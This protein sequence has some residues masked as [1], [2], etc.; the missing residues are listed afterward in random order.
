MLISFY[1]KHKIVSHGTVQLRCNQP[2]SVLR[3][4]GH[5]V[6]VKTIYLSKPRKGELVILHRAKYDR[7][8]SL[9][10]NYAR[11]LGCTIWYDLDDLLFSPDAER[12]L[13]HIGN[14][15]KDF[16]ANEY[17][18]CIKKC[19]KIL[20]STA[21]LKQQLSEIHAN[22]E[23]V[24]NFLSQGFINIAKTVKAS[25]KANKAFTLGYLSGSKSHDKDIEQLA[26][27]IVQFM[28]K[29][30]DVKLLVVGHL[31]LP[32]KLE[33]LASKIETRKFIPYDK[34]PEVYNEIDLNLVPLEKDEAFCQA[35]SELKYIE[36]GACGVASVA[37]ATSPYM[38]AI[39]HGRNGYLV[40]ANEWFEI[41]EFAYQDRSLLYENADAAFEDVIERYTER[42][43]SLHWKD[44]LLYYNPVVPID[45]SMKYSLYL[46]LE[47]MRWIRLFK[48]AIKGFGLR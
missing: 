12:Y 35:K 4:M 39:D 5:D 48:R 36:A 38:D 19:D 23:V 22:V 45:K 32:P 44:I 6:R 34:L 33:K 18:E 24:R 31:T 1:S 27:G 14:K 9:F 30:D 11:S 40:K 16:V 3:S 29:H 10:I 47:R 20:V 17:L 26:D 15:R 7:H 2:A 8:T 42:S 25:P 28:Q 46:R 43:A 37:T 21:Y 13:S 41:M